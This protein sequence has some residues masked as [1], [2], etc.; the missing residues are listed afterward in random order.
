LETRL[1]VEEMNAGQAIALFRVAL[2][3][4]TDQELLAAL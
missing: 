3:A 4:T 2:T 1:V